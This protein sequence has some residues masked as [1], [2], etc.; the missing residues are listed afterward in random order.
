MTYYQQNHIIGNL[1]QAVS[2]L[3]VG[4]PQQGRAKDGGDGHG[5]HEDP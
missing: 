5:D 3:V 2:Y 4:V 1:A